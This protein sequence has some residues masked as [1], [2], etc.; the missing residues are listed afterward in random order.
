M[1]YYRDN[2]P[3]VFL[4]SDF[5]WRTSDGVA[6]TRKKLIRT[7][8]DWCERAELDAT[9]YNGISMRK[10][11]ALSL[12]MAGVEDHIIRGMGRWKD[13]CYTRYIEDV[14]GVVRTAQLAM[15]LLWGASGEA[16]QYT[17]DELWDSMQ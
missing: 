6:L 17:A 15:G 7:I 13:A 9:E 12:S 11:G 16:H 8:R 4:P 3:F 14:A 5:L 1:A 10:G 2:A